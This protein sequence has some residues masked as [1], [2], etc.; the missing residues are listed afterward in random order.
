MAEEKK[1]TQVKIRNGNGDVTETIPVAVSVNNIKYD[2]NTSL[3]TKIDSLQLDTKLDKNLGSDKEGQFLMVSSSG[4]VVSENL[5][6]TV[7]KQALQIPTDLAQFENET[8]FVREEDLKNKYS[9]EYTQQAS[10]GTITGNTIN[11]LS[12]SLENLQQT[13]STYIDTAA[14]TQSENKQQIDA[15]DRKMNDIYSFMQGAQAYYNTRKDLEDEAINTNTAK[16]IIDNT[17]DIIQIKQDINKI[18]GD[19]AAADQQSQ[20]TSGRIGVL[21]SNF[22]TFKKSLEDVNAVDKLKQIYFSTSNPTVLFGDRENTSAIQIWGNADNHVAISATNLANNKRYAILARTG[23][24]VGTGNAISNRGIAIYNYTDEIW[25]YNTDRYEPGETVTLTNGQIYAGY[26]TTGGKDLKFFIPLRKS[27]RWCP[28]AD[29]KI[30]WNRATDDVLIIRG[31]KGLISNQT[32]T[33]Q[34]YFNPKNTKS[35]NNKVTT[36]CYPK[37]NGIE[38]RFTGVNAF[39]NAVTNTPITMHLSAHD[40]YITL[41]TRPTPKK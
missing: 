10:S 41:G 20:A 30:N 4:D 1:L 27:C 34:Y 17:N 26:V 37:E 32:G 23:T 6:T 11:N 35:V 25:E 29:F 5:N 28:S 22:E 16:Q 12:N 21:E 18:L 38:I 7:I 39:T 13:F 15:L 40:M 19:S 33:Y 3:K 9:L 31:I 24:S 14:S 36:T 8:K 2:G